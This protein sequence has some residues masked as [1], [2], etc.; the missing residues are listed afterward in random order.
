MARS[1]FSRPSSAARAKWPPARTR[2]HLP[3]PLAV[4][5]S[6]ALRRSVAR[7]RL[8]LDHRRR[9]RTRGSVKPPGSHPRLSAGRLTSRWTIT[10]APRRTGST[11]NLPP[12]GPP[13]T[14]M[15]RRRRTRSAS[16]K[17]SMTSSAGLSPEVARREPNSA[18]SAAASRGKTCRRLSCGLQLPEEGRRLFLWPLGCCQY[19]Q[20]SPS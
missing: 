14:T 20:L 19:H 17:A 2:R 11:R 10:R 12:L 9:Y 3:P 7:P 4:A 8:P 6:P 5:P 18:R 1:V 13:S 16:A 15:E